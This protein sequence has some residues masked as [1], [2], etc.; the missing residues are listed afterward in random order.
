M[1]LQPVRLA[2]DPSGF[3]AVVDHTSAT[4]LAVQLKSVL[5]PSFAQMSSMDGCRASPQP[6]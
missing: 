6:Q 4:D 3:V 5:K 2:E 1:Q